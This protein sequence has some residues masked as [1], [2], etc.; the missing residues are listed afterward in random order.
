M[1]WVRG[2][3]NFHFGVGLQPRGPKMG[4]LKERP[5]TKNIGLKN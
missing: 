5:G 4:G 2:V 1:T 3:L